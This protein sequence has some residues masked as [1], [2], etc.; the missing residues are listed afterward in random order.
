MRLCIYT[1]MS[2]LHTAWL[3]PALNGEV[4]HLEHGHHFLSVE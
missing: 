1:N 3:K 2:I 4:L